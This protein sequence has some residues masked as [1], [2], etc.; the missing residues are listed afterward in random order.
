[1]ATQCPQRVN[2][3]FPLLHFTLEAFHS[4]A[5]KLT[6]CLSHFSSV[7]LA[8][9]LLF[10]RRRARN[11]ALGRE[12]GVE[13]GLRAARGGV[14]VTAMKRLIRIKGAVSCGDACSNRAGINKSEAE[15]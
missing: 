15:Y 10:F 9:A 2:E 4:T 3:S 11:P 6:S 5:W 14:V 7:C 13:A 8:L 12:K 1:M